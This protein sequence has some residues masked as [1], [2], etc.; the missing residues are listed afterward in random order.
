[1]DIL[2]CSLYDLH[3]GVFFCQTLGRMGRAHVNAA[4]LKLLRVN[5]ILKVHIN[6]AISFVRVALLGSTPNDLT[7]ERR[8]SPFIPTP[9]FLISLSSLLTVAAMH[10]NVPHLVP[11]RQSSLSLS[12]CQRSTNHHHKQLKENRCASLTAL[13]TAPTAP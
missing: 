9:S 2:V 6:L 4:C 11:T 1:M 8:Y 5:F 12:L 10:W 7:K 13:S 3:K